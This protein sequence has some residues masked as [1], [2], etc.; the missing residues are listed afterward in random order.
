MPNEP[1]V[2]NDFGKKKKGN[3]KVL[4]TQFGNIK[5]MCVCGGEERGCWDQNLSCWNCVRN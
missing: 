1:E 5:N 4:L 2:F 3:Y